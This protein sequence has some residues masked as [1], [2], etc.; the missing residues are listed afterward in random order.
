MHITTISFLSVSISL[1]V[2][3]HCKLTLALLVSYPTKRCSKLSY[4]TD[5]TLSFKKGSA[6]NDQGNDQ[7]N[8]EN[9]GGLFKW[10]ALPR[11]SSWKEKLFKSGATP[12]PATGR[13]YHIRIKNL[14]DINSRHVSHFVK[15]FYDEYFHE[16]H[17]YSYSFKDS[18]MNRI[19]GLI[20]NF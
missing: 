17:I 6:G 14:R 4:H 18:K 19:G 1:F 5:T 2:L 16:R 12:Q 7:G 11:F 8:D 13:R 10:F 20:L 15:Q 3:L 9:K